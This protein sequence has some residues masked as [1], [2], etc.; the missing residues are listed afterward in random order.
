[1]TTKVKTTCRKEILSS[2]D[3]ENLL[4][5]MCFQGA[6]EGCN[7]GFQQYCQCLLACDRPDL[8]DIPKQLLERVSLA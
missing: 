7:L 5:I 6:I 3:T 4:V 1:M 2:V 8:F